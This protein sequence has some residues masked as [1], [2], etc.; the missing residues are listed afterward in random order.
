MAKLLK[1]KTLSMPINKNQKAV[2]EFVLNLNNFPKWAKMFCS[3]IKKSKDEWIAQTPQGQVR[4][5]ISK[6]NDFG[7][8]DHH[9][10]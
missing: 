4:V 2:Y 7:V 3:S 10:T 1:S 8:L 6:R 5:K 9:V